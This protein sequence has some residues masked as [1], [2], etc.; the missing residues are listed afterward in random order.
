VDVQTGRSEQYRRFAARCLEIAHS[1]QTPQ[2][3]A[4]MLKMAQVWSRLAEDTRAAPDQEQ[5]KER[6]T[7]EDAED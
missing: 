6:E 7:A 3:K 5:E 4:V 1:I 2:T